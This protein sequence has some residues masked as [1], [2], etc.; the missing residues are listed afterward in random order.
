VGVQTAVERRGDCSHVVLLVG[1][2]GEAFAGGV[3]ISLVAGEHLVIEGYPSS[4]ADQPTIDGADSLFGMRV[5]GEGSLSL[6]HLAIRRG[7]NGSGGCLEADVAELFLDDTSWEACTAAD[8]GG[9]IWVRAQS[10]SVAASHFRGN[11]AGA[12][13]GAGG[14]VTLAGPADASFVVSNSIFRENQAAR[15]GAV[16]VLAPTVDVRVEGSRFLA[17]ISVLAGSAIY[18]YLGGRIIGNRFE[19]N[20]GGI[21]GG[22]VAGQAGWYLAEL[23]QNV[24]VENSTRNVDSGGTSCCGAA[25]AVDLSPAYITIRN[26]LFVR[27]VSLPDPT[28]G[29]AGVGAVRFT[30]GYP[31]VVNNTFVENE[32][33]VPDFV[34]DNGDVRN[35]LFV[36]SVSPVAINETDGGGEAQVDYNNV[37]PAPAPFFAGDAAIGAGNLANDPAFLSAPTDDF[38]LAAGSPCIDAGD[39]SGECRDGDGTRNDIG[40]FGGPGGAWTPLEGEEGSS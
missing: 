16:A 31:R 34:G 2:A 36:G 28:Y 17:N 25:A 1:P 19:S 40:A 20:V 13:T 26:N 30:G 23:A 14:A 4:G 39:P 9:A 21:Q 7:R 33:A 8:Q 35:N 10:V 6:Q 3:D 27:N 32:G 18:G 12:T 15:G 11:S 37:W 29:S 5:T 24:F 22:A 38:R